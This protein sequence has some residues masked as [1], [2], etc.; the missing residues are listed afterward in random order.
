MVQFLAGT[1]DTFFFQ[2]VRTSFIVKEASY[3]LGAKSTLPR[4]KWLGHEACHSYLVPIFRMYEAI[5]PFPHMV[6]A[7]T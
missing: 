5:P 6:L 7:F 2:N 1:R 3:S 4:G